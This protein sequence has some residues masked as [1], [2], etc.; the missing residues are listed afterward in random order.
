MM[1]EGYAEFH[2]AFVAELHHPALLIDV[3]N[4]GGGYISE[5]ILEKLTR[6][7]LGYDIRRWGTPIAYPYRFATSSACRG[8]RRAR[9]F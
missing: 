2:R 5:Y 1:V 6:R 8:Y 3:R 7:C 4:N 9:W